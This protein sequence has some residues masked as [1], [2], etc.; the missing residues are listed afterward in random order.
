MIQY[1]YIYINIYVY[2]VYVV[3]T[4]LDLPDDGCERWDAV[5]AGWRGEYNNIVFV[6]YYSDGTFIRRRRLA[7]HVCARACACPHWL[8]CNYYYILCR[9]RRRHLFLT[10]SQLHLSTRPYFCYMHSRV[11]WFQRRREM[12][13]NKGTLLLSSSSSGTRHTTFLDYLLQVHNI[14]KR[15]V[16]TIGHD[17]STYRHPTVYLRT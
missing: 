16:F 13:E 4:N 15:S 11:R 14:I 5:S 17:L 6:V 8:E 2:F 9:H 3:V 10:E 7:E 1:I 12:S